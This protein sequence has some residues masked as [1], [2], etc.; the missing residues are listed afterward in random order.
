MFK[1]VAREVRTV[2]NV[3]A[4]EARAKHSYVVQFCA[5]SAQYIFVVNLATMRAKRAEPV[6]FH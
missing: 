3:D 1:D 6:W 5:R 2:L 4:R